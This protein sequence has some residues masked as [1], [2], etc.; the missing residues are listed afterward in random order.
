ME[1]KIFKDRQWGN[2]AYMD[3]EGTVY[4]KNGPDANSLISVL[5]GEWKINKSYFPYD[6]TATDRYKAG[7]YLTCNRTNTR[8]KY[9]INPPLVDTLYSVSKSGVNPML[10]LKKENHVLTSD[11]LYESIMK[12]PPNNDFLTYTT[13]DM[14]SSFVYYRY[15]WQGKFSAQLWNYEKG[16]MIGKV[17]L[18]TDRYGFNYVFDSGNKVRISPIYVTD[19]CLAFMIPAEKCVGEIDGVKE[20]DNPVLMVMKLK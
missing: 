1:E 3:P 16:K 6:S 9:V 20:D 17:D 13:L 14:F 7:F 4:T 2:I 5:D 10:I 11:I 18:E 12:L 8:D 15:L 19:K